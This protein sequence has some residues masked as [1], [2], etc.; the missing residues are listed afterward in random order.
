MKPLSA[1]ERAV[2]EARTTAEVTPVDEALGDDEEP[3]ITDTERLARVLT[4]IEYYCADEFF[5]ELDMDLAFRPETLDERTKE[6]ARRIGAIYRIS[7]SFNTSHS[8][9]HAHEAW[10][11][12]VE[13]IRTEKEQGK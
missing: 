11:K 8:C 12:E 5:E 13:A 1:S 9:H 4:A 3:G 6:L 2:E 7:H 10:R